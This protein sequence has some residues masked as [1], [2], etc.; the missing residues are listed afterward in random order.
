MVIAG[1]FPHSLGAFAILDPTL[2]IGAWVL[3]KRKT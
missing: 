2:A 1:I 3:H